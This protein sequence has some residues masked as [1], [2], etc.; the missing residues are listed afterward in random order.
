[1]IGENNDYSYV[2]DELKAICDIR[3]AKTICSECISTIYRRI[4]WDTLPKICSTN[5]R[6]KKEDAIN[7]LVRYSK[8]ISEYEPLVSEYEAEQLRESEQLKIKIAESTPTP[9]GLYPHEMFAIIQWKHWVKG[10][11]KEYI[12]SIFADYTKMVCG[13]RNMFPIM[14]DMVERGFLELG[15][16][17]YTVEKQTNDELRRFLKEHG[18]KISG[19]KEVLVDRIFNAIDENEICDTYPMKYYKQTEKGLAAL[20]DWPFFDRIAFDAGHSIWNVYS[21]IYVGKP[22]DIW[23]ISNAVAGKGNLSLE[24]LLQIVECKQVDLNRLY[25]ARFK[26]DPKMDVIVFDDGRTGYISPFM[27][28]DYRN[29]IIMYIRYTL[30]KNT[31]KAG[32]EESLLSAYNSLS[33]VEKERFN[34]KYGKSVSTPTLS[35]LCSKI[36]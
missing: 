8:A 12:S 18:Q 27:D 20:A 5:D 10:G 13:V 7:K 11:Q 19:K 23:E 32:V 16:L 26:D 33:D 29:N 2:L 35:T 15:D 17:R 22:K 9:H 4:I 6:K 24:E 31:V 30:T 36:S 34:E 28:R 21:P 3:K 1:M 25:N 14:D